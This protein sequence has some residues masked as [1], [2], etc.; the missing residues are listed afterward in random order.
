MVSASHNPKQYNGLKMVRAKASPMG[1]ETG[2]YEIRDLV[3]T[4]QFKDAEKKGEIS[5]KEGILSEEVEEQKKDIDWKRI[6]PM[7]VVA[8]AAN[9]MGA[10]DMEAMFKDLPLEVIQLNFE[11]DG[12]FPSHPADPLEE[13][14]L[15]QLKGA[16]KKE[17]ADIGIA[18]DGDGDRYFFVDEKGETV[19]QPILRG[20]MAQIELEKNP[21]ATVC[22]DIRPGRITREMIEEAGGNPCVTKVGHSLIKKKMLEVDAI[23]GGESSGHYFYKFDYGTFEAPITFVLKFLTYVSKVDKPVSEIIAPYDKYYH[24]GEINFEVDQKEEKVE[25]V[26][27]KYEGTCD[28]SKLDGITVTCEDFWFNIRPSNTESLLRLALEATSKEKMEEKKKEIE[29]MIKG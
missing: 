2:I 28:I 27:Q 4:G 17:G 21:G 3:K 22:Y 29:M 23:F 18:S 26:A 6:K 15:K 12:T 11:L 20:L 13:D 1:G 25:K 10:V 8:D 14:N 9:S 5:K 7:K 24:S 19:P 16:V